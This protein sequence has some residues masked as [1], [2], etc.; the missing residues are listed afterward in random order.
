[1]TVTVYLTDPLAGDRIQLECTQATVSE[2]L[3]EGEPVDEEGLV[4]VP[5]SNVAGIEADSRESELEQHPMQ[6]GQYT[7]FRTK[8]S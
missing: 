5:M 2:G 8:L 7:Q 3:L 1:M 4:I 6:G